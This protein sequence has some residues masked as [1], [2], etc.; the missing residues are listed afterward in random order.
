M[1]PTVDAQVREPLHPGDEI[2]A[3]RP[4]APFSLARLTGLR[5]DKTLNQKLGWG[6]QLRYRRKD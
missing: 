4:A 6:G 3:R 2:I 5:D 1:I